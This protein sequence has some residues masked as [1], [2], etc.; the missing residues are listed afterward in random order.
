LDGGAASGG[1][2]TSLQ[3]AAS[4]QHAVASADGAQRTATD[5]LVARTRA[6]E[7]GFER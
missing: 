2:I 6:T 7:F 1:E 3:A 5:E 4:A